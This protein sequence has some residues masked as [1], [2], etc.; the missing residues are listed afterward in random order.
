MYV[1]N[2]LEGIKT[3]GERRKECPSLLM[4]SIM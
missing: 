3:M 1:E 2:P 4:F